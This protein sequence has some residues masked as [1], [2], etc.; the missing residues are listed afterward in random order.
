MAHIEVDEGNHGIVSLFMAYPQSEPH[1]NGLVQHLL[2]EET[3]GL[4]REYRELI[5]AFVS[6]VNEC[7]FC[8]LVHGAVAAKLS[9]KRDFLES[10]ACDLD[11]A[12]LPEKVKA[13]L[14][15][16]RKVAIDGKSV[17]DEDIIVARDHGANDRDIHDTVL[18]AAAFC[19]LNRYVDALGTTVPDDTEYYRDTA[20]QLIRY[21]Y[22]SR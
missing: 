1:L 5:A 2:R 9:G 11:S 4:S 17:S 19:M 6:R 7:R 13:L 16:A 10:A 21:G 3:P 15:I 18:I 14:E 20:E 22:S 8:T 12:D